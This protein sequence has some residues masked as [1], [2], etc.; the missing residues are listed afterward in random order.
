M[1]AEERALK[2]FLHAR[3]YDA[4]AVQAVRAEAQRDPRRLVRRLSRRSRPGCRRNGGRASADPVAVAR[5]V[6]DF[7]AGMTDRYAVRRYEELIGPA[8]LLRGV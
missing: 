4:P 6:G 3:M 1:A 2:A 7:I 8:R 5:A